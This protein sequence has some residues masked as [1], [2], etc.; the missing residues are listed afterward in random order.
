M[1]AYCFY[2]MSN[3]K[4]SHYYLLHSLKLRRGYKYNPVLNAV[5]FDICM[6]IDKGIYPSIAGLSF[7]DKLRDALQLENI[8]SQGVAL[9]YRA[10]MTAAVK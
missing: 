7:D 8:Y 4:K 3:V 1:L 9:R 5:I 6:A 10:I 2:R